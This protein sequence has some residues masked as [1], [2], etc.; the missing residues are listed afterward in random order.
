[1]TTLFETTRKPVAT[2]LPLREVKLRAI[3]HAL[4]QCH[5][6]H[7]LAALLLGIG[8]TTVYRMEK[9]YKSQPPTMQGE[10]LATGVSTFAR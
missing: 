1:M 9:E 5:G 3:L 8:K 4:D 2:I 10:A 7:R 6:N